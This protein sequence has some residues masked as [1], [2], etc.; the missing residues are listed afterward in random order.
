MPQNSKPLE[1]KR[2][3]GNPG[4]QKLPP[5]SRIVALPKAPVV[6]PEHLIGAAADCWRD[7]MATAP[8]VAASDATF[9]VELCELVGNR[10]VMQ[11]QVE[12]DGMVLVSPNGAYQAHPLLG[13]IRDV[14]KQIHS[15]ASLYGLTPSDRGRIGLGEVQAQSKIEALAAKRKAH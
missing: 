7:V 5:K 10:A 3:L 2:A 8:W 1:L 11:A 4:H 6:P 15:L 9:L 13:H 14:T 12:K